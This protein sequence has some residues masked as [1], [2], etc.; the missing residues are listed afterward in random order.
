MDRRI[1]STMVR[2]RKKRTMKKSYSNRH[3]IHGPSHPSEKRR[4]SVLGVRRQAGI[5]DSPFGGRAGI[6]STVP[7]SFSI[8]LPALLH[9]RDGHLSFQVGG[10]T[11]SLAAHSEEW[12]WNEI[13]VEN[14]RRRPITLSDTSRPCV[15]AWP[16]WQFGGNS[17][18]TV[19][20]R[21]FFLGA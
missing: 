11:E 8:R 3:S 4:K 6:C 14:Y 19:Q 16:L 15:L 12:S 1:G 2:R 5:V 18:A 13:I 17:W 21:F 7:V 9:N 10:T 20:L